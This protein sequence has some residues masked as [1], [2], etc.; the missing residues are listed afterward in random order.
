MGKLDLKK[1]YKHLYLPGS[2]EVVLVDVPEFQF[3]MVDGVIPEGESP[4]SS[5][6]FTNAMSALYGISYGLKF[7]SKLQQDDPIDYTVM[8]MEA[9]WWVESGQFEME[10]AEPWYFRAMILQPAH[11]SSEMYLEAR[12]DLQAKKPELDLSD[13]RLE[14]FEEGRS[15]QIMHI[16]PYSDEPRTL[17]KMDE[18]L[19][20]H[21][22]KY[23]GD[24]H[25]IY[26]GDPRRAKPENLRTVLR[27]AVEPI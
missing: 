14:R 11:I 25:E 15:I 21:D 12:R 9:M 23:R 22:L 4:D 20:E 19:D 26:L 16:G 17:A 24:H 7:M 3:A 5:T 27:H 1:K 8:A 10:K 6:S 2:K 13:L 18:F